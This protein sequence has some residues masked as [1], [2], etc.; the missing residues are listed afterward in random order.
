MHDAP[1]RPR[2]NE[3]TATVEKEQTAFVSD[4]THVRGRKP[5][6]THEGSYVPEATLTLAGN[7]VTYSFKRGVTEHTTESCI[8]VWRDGKPWG[9]WTADSGW[10]LYRGR[11][12][13]DG[14]APY[15]LRECAAL[16]AQ[17]NLGTEAGQ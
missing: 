7:P 2:S 5:L 9:F 17:W 16:W 11:A 14:H 4:H 15:V 13:L 3:R 12:G 10:H 8:G 1:G 6:E